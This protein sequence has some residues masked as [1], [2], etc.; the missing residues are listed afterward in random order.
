MATTPGH[1][2]TT[3]NLTGRVYHRHDETRVPMTLETPPGGHIS[4]DGDRRAEFHWG[5]LPY[6]CPQCDAVIEADYNVRA[7]L[8]TTFEHPEVAWFHGT[9]PESGGL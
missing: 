6:R 3:V 1:I 9:G 4:F 8:N 7:D 2:G 5:V